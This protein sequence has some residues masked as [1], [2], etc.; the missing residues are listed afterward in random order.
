M[1]LRGALKNF[2]EEFY[3]HAAHKRCMVSAGTGA[4][5]A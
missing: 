1:A 4:G 5:V 3:F 2:K